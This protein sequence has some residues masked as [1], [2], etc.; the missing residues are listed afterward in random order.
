LK[1][2]WQRYTVL[3]T[4][5]LSYLPQM[6]GF[7]LYVLPSTNYSEEFRQT[8]AGKIVARQLRVALTRQH[9]IEK[10]TPLAK[11]TIPTDV[12]SSRIT[13]KRTHIDN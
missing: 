11:S 2:S 10:K 5:F 3:T 12:L 6:L 7:I 8:L 4:Y 9:N 13:T 1:Q